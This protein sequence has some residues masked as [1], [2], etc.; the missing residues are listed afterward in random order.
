MKYMYILLCSVLV[1]VYQSIS[2]DMSELI[3]EMNSVLNAW[4]LQVLV[5]ISSILVIHYIWKVTICVFFNVL[6]LS[7]RAHLNDCLIYY[8]V[9]IGIT[10][11]YY[12]NHVSLAMIATFSVLLCSIVIHQLAIYRLKNT[13]HVDTLVNVRHIGPLQ[14]LL[15]V[16]FM[17]D[18]VGLC[19]ICMS[20]MV[21][22]PSSTM[23]F[24]LSLFSD[25]L[26]ILKAV[27][28]VL[29][30]GI[31]RYKG[32]FWPHKSMLMLLNE[33]CISILTLATTFVGAPRVLGAL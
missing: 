22:G 30:I 11:S 10:L 24:V 25:I 20:T 4:C 23:L 6:T 18:T 15:T 28:D 19:Y 5:F 8:T 13:M 3:A 21:Y 27:V 7:E 16:L 2:G 29:V 17:M 1:Y 33:L 12:Y 26:S 14:L 9:D 31:E 32:V